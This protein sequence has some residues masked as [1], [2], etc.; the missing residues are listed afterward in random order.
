MR[1]LNTADIFTALRI[2][3]ET[4]LKEQLTTVVIKAKEE[5]QEVESVGKEVT[6]KL[7]EFLLEQK[8]ERKLYEFLSAPFEVTP[9]DVEKMPIDKLIENLEELSKI[10]NFQSFF[11]SLSKLTTLKSLKS[12]IQNSAT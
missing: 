4:G 7:F 9:E 11:T 12:S 3:N 1:T 5:N 6:L 10:S 8:T 2:L